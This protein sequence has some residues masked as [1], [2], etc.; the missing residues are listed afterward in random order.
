MG[1]SA[2]AVRIGSA[3]QRPAFSHAIALASRVAAFRLGIPSLAK[4]RAV[5]GD[6][7]SA[8]EARAWA[9]ELRARQVRLQLACL[10]D[11]TPGGWHPR[12]TLSGVEHLDDAAAQGRGA[13]LWFDNFAYRS[14]VGL[15][16]FARHGHSIVVLS[17]RSHGVSTTRFGIKWL[18]RPWIRQQEQHVLERIVF[19]RADVVA[20][21]RHVVRL[22]EQHHIVAIANNGDMGA[23]IAVAL[24]PAQLP[25]ATTPL[26]LAAKGVPVLPVTVLETMPLAEFTI[27]IGAPLAPFQADDRREAIRRMGSAYA[28]TLLP[29]I[30]AN[31]DQW[32]GWRHIRLP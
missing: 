5:L 22:L 12:L 17:A 8:A 25:V 16:A 1:L 20:A 30:R 6:R 23:K 31:P 29:Q 11:L 26:G 32:M 2:A 14:V 18:N 13:I 7:V 15:K 9:I 27:A 24:G 4:A 21:T 28:D 3:W 10:A 19:T